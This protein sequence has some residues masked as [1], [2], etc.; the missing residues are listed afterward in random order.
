MFLRIK[1]HNQLSSL[2]LPK[3][4]ISSTKNFN[5]FFALLSIKDNEISPEALKTEKYKI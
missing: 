4:N 1:T 3:L 5:L 2:T